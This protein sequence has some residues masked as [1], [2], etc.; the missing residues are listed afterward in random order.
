MVSWDVDADV[1]STVAIKRGA[2]KVTDDSGHS[3]G[4]RSVDIGVMTTSAVASNPGASTRQRTVTQSLAGQLVTPIAPRYVNGSV[5]HAQ[6]YLGGKPLSTET[7][8]YRTRW[9]DITQRP[10][11]KRNIVVVG[12]GGRVTSGTG[13]L[14]S[15]PESPTSTKWDW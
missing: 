8:E 2:V 10:M 5:L 7:I 12:K 3:F 14:Y 11:V 1:T 6:Y 4:R 13:I 15:A 9:S